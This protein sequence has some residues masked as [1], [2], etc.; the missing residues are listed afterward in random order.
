MAICTDELRAGMSFDGSY[1][2]IIPRGLDLAPMILNFS[3]RNITDYAA[4]GLRLES[5]NREIGDPRD[6]LAVRRGFRIFYWGHHKL[7]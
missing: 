5:A 4:A 6:F 3:I 1:I 7:S 2:F